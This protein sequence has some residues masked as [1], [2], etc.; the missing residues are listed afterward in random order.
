[1]PRSAPTGPEQ[2]FEEA[3]S[4]WLVVSRRYSSDPDTPFLA[5]T[6]ADCREMKAALFLI[7]E[8]A[9]QGPRASRRA[10]GTWGI[11]QAGLQRAAELPDSDEVASKGLKSKGI[12]RLNLISKKCT[13]NAWACL[14]IIAWRWSG[15][16]GRRPR[17]CTG[18]VPS[19]GHVRLRKGGVAAE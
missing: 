12:Q 5:N 4:R 2:L 10:E 11:P 14:R 6:D 1:M 7:E 15:T 9:Y 13:V 19:R 17:L 16:E 3:L 8:A 18:A